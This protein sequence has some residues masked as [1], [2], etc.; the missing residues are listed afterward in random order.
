MLGAMLSARQ[1]NALKSHPLTRPLYRFYRDAKLRRGARSF[2]RGLVRSGFADADQ[3]Q[4]IARDW[5]AVA[6]HTQLSQAGILNLETAARYVTDN[7]LRGAFVECGT[8]RG[9]ALAFWARALL[10]N[11]GKPQDNP[12]FGFDSFEGMPDVTP[13]DGDWAARMLHGKGIDSLSAAELGGALKPHAM[14]AAEESA[15]RAIVAASGFP[16]AHSHIVKGWFQDTL[17][18]WKTRIGPIAV[19]RLDGDWYQSTKTCLEQL[20]DQVVPGGIVI[21]DDY[22][23][24][25]GC[26]KAVNEFMAGRGL[27]PELLQADPCVRY[28]VK[29]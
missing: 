25:V 18:A 6:D 26:Q 9:G 4:A 11:G 8:W 21:V 2:R 1:R 22:G 19:L 14:N 27:K 3:A 13:Q 28:F 20:Y 7:A 29:R 24:F 17:P 5:H 15:C 10:R 12:I 16:A 23:F